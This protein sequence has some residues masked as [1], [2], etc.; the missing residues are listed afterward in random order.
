MINENTKEYAILKDLLE[1]GEKMQVEVVERRRG[2]AKWFGVAHAY[3]T[4]ERIIVIRIYVLGLKK[5]VKIIKCSDIMQTEI[6]RGLFY[7][8]VHFSLQGEQDGD[9]RK[10]IVGLTYAE[11]LL[12]AKYKN[13]SSTHKGAK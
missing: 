4:D 12:L 9:S 11:A 5:S 6:E 13:K 10:W 8:K 1:E 7:S 3:A 2:G